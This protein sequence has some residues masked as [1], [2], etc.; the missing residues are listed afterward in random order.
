M[1]PAFHACGSARP[2]R[3]RCC[4]SCQNRTN[5]GPSPLLTQFACSQ[6]SEAS[7]R[8]SQYKQEHSTVAGSGDR[9]GHGQT[10]E[11]SSHGQSHVSAAEKAQAAAAMGTF[12]PP[13]AGG[14]PAG[15]PMPPRGLPP[16]YFPGMP[17]PLGMMPPPLPPWM[18]G[19]QSGRPNYAG[20]QCN[21][22]DNSMCDVD[23]CCRE[24][25]TQTMLAWQG[26]LAFVLYGWCPIYVCMY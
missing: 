1:S 17:P 19:A 4:H 13:A 14:P 11:H 15:M 25:E 9:Y 21:C 3:I 6:M 22:C 23:W 26:D 24:S 8:A 10:R 7:L 16:G 12:L 2:S 18:L 20:K 5:R